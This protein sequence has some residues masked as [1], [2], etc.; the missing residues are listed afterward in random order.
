M[1]VEIFFRAFDAVMK[2]FP[3]SIPKSRRNVIPAM[4]FLQSNWRSTLGYADG[5]KTAHSGGPER[6]CKQTRAKSVVSH[7]IQNSFHCDRDV[8]NLSFVA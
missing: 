4:A 1:I 5:G 2:T 8:A 3:L 7:L 6:N